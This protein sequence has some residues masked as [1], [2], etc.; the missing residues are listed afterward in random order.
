MTAVLAADLRTAARLGPE[1]ARA[2]AGPDDVNRPG[3]RQP[4]DLP[5]RG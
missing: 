3:L 5:V 4:S 2:G 1:R